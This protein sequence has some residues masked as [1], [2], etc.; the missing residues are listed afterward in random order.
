MTSQAGHVEDLGVGAQ[1]VTWY[2]SGGG[3]VHGISRLQGEV[4]SESY[5]GHRM[6]LVQEDGAEYDVVEEAT[7]ACRM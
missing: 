1:L 3:L 2:H 5:D 6:P 7:Q 4:V